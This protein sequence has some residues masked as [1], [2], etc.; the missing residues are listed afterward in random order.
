MRKPIQD[1]TGG[2]TLTNQGAP[3]RRQPLSSDSAAS[4]H[5][6]LQM[7]RRVDTDGPQDPDP[8]P[9]PSCNRPCTFILDAHRDS[10]IAAAR[11]GRHYRSIAAQYGINSLEVWRIVTDELKTRKAAA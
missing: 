6:V 2:S 4:N 8:T 5:R 7:P 9:K 3:P 1:Q 10:I 11:N